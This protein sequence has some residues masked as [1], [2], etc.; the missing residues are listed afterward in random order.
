MRILIVVAIIISLFLIYE[1]LS[2]A[3]QRE[4]F[5]KL[6]ES[7]RAEYH[8]RKRDFRRAASDTSEGLRSQVSRA[9]RQAGF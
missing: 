5:T 1:A 8:R 4:P 7:G 9:L 3:D 6:I 2:V